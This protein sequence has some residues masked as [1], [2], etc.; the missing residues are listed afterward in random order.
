MHLGWLI[1]LFV[2]VTR[3]WVSYGIF[4]VNVTNPVFEFYFNTF[5]LIFSRKDAFNV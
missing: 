4:L 3:Y 2:R 5:F 1:H